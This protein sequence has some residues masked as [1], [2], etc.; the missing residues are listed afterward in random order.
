MNATGFLNYEKLANRGPSHFSADIPNR[1]CYIYKIKNIKAA[2]K[3]T[4]KQLTLY[5]ANNESRFCQGVTCNN[6]INC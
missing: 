4:I 1:R 5:E 6:R 2:K 3:Y